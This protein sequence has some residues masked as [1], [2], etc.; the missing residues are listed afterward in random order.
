M[1]LS[2]ADK[3]GKPRTSSQGQIMVASAT[4]DDAALQGRWS[5]L[6]A[7]WPVGA[8]PNAVFGRISDHFDRGILSAAGGDVAA[9]IVLGPWDAGSSVLARFVRRCQDRDI[10]VLIALPEGQGTRASLAP[11]HGLVAIPEHLGDLALAAVLVG[12]VERQAAVAVLRRELAIEQSIK[13]S[14]ASQL[15]QLSREIDLAA[16]VQKSFLP[17]VLSTVPGLETAVLF[18]PTSTLSGD[19]YNIVPLDD[20]TVG[21][22]VADACGHGVS[23]AMLTMLVTNLLQ[24]KE[25]VG[26]ESRVVPPAEVLRRFNS[27]FIARRG[28]ESLLITAL[29]GT[30]NQRTGQ[31]HFASAGHPPPIVVGPGGMRP[32][33]GSGPALGLFADAEFVSLATHL[34]LDQTLLLYTDGFEQAFVI[35]ADIG[36]R[37]RRPSELYREF[38]LRHFANRRPGS[39]GTSIDALAHEMDRQHG[40][41][42][43]LDDITLLGLGR[44]PIPDASTQIAFEAAIESI[45]RA[46]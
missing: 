23:A 18:R 8:A 15:A 46:A 28:D 34:E 19:I 17:T 3:V 25:T 35:E 22:F 33:D 40:S 26:V 24:M 32:L 36:T 37:R 1:S 45:A 21:F 31:V 10:P 11:G 41:L 39:L 4:L 9:A 29:Y 42:H 12:F 20:E 5:Q 27:Q 38:F 2:D 16:R 14:A 6:A 44:V 30:I 13:D 43:P 7:A